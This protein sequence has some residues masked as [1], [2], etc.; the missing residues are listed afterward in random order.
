MEKIHCHLRWGYFVNVN[1][2]VMTT[3]EFLQDDFSLSTT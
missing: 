3:V 1:Q 2:I